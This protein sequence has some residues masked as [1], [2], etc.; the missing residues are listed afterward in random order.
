V[1]ATFY[2]VKMTMKK[3]MMMVVVVVMMKQVIIGAVGLQV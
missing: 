3:K 2:E 1:S